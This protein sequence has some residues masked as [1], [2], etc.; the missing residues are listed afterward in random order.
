[1]LILVLLALGLA[2]S[3]QVVWSQPAVDPAPP[4]TLTEMENPHGGFGPGTQLCLTCHSFRASQ[5]ALSNALCERCHTMPTHME[6]NCVDCH[7]PHGQTENLAL[8]RETV[9]DQPVVFRQKT[10][11][12]SLSEGADDP[13]ALCVACHTKTRFHRPGA[14]ETHFEEQDCTRCHQHQFGFWPENIQCRDCHTSIPLPSGDH[15]TH[16]QAPYGPV[17]NR[18]SSCHWKVTTWKVHRDGKVEFADEQRLDKTVACDTCHGLGGP[19]AK[20][21]WGTGQR[22]DCVTCHNPE[23]PAQINGATA[24]PIGEFW[25]ASGHGNTTGFASGNPGAGLSCDACHDPN[26]PHIGVADGNYRL[27]AEPTAL[28]LSCHG[29]RGSASVKVSTHGN[30]HFGFRFEEQFQVDCTDCHDPHGT[31]NLSMI[32]TEIRGT[33]VTFTARTGPGSFDA[34]DNDNRN[35]LCATCH[36]QTRHNRVPGN[37]AETPHFEGMDCTSCHKHDRDE[38]PETVDGFVLGDIGCVFCH[39]QPPPPANSGYPLD[40]TRTP[41]QIHAGNNGYGFGCE[42]CHDTSNPNYAGH[43]T[44]PPS[45]QDV[46]F[47][48][49][50]PNG[51]YD[52]D[53]RTCGGLYCHSNGD[54]AGDTPIEYRPMVWAENVG[55]NCDG[56]HGDATS[57]TTNAHSKHL[58]PQ[59]RDRGETSIGCYECHSA[60]AVD[61]DNNAISNRSNHVDRVKQVAIDETDLWGDAGSANFDSANL[62][63]ANSRCH[64]D[65]AASRT[66]PGEP[67][68]ASPVWTEPASGACGTCHGISKDTLTTGI[69]PKHLAFATCTTCHA[70]YGP[71]HVNGQVDFADGNT[72]SNTTVCGQCHG[73]QASGQSRPAPAAGLSQTSTPTT[74]P[75]PIVAETP[76][77]TATEMPTPT[78]TPT[79]ALIPTPGPTPSPTPEP[80]PAPI[81]TPVPKPILVPIKPPGLLPTVPVP[82]AAE[83]TPAAKTQ[84]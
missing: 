44:D 4:V 70:G 21:L 46:W 58:L 83:R 27:R 66:V 32:R 81:P 75:S 50:N 76:M 72:F 84:A 31:R 80:M 14:T 29:E 42:R 62:S 2:F 57:Q 7:D 51:Q 41:H 1:M 24:P 10:G 9:N 15:L 60:T 35:D 34:P 40:E 38:R 5:Q 12:D 17:T 53:A 74:T 61:D 64:S 54:P 73:S 3:Y 28:C 22:L 36:T 63:C 19:Q 65:G 26:A 56:C 30:T 68:Y 79:A 47:N 71:T 8:I 48:D 78:P 18:C 16:A 20:S 13:D 67:T 82:P 37:Q 55:L 69:H 45:F 43:R 25:A 6:Q 33:P 59:Y 49:F 11:K 77:Q 23:K 39:G 52:A